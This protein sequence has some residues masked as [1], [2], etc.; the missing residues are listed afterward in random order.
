MFQAQCRADVNEA[1]FL[2]DSFIPLTGA[3][4]TV[5]YFNRKHKYNLN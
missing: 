4:L 2:V 1:N 3:C 5:P